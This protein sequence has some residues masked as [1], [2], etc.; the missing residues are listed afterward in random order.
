MAG[1]FKKN[2]FIELCSFFGKPAPMEVVKTAADGMRALE[3]LLVQVPDAENPPTLPFGSGNEWDYRDRKFYSEP[4][5]NK[6]ADYVFKDDILNYSHDFSGWLAGEALVSVGWSTQDN[7]I[8]IGL[9][10]FTDTVATAELTFNQ[11]GGY[12]VLIAAT[13]TNSTDKLTVKKNFVISDPDATGL[14][15]DA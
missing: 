5:N 3:Q 8:S 13:K 7:G 10:G 15:Y 6:D 4:P 12:Y 14:R 2:L 9:D 1:P 11:P